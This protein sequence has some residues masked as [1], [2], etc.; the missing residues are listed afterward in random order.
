MFSPPLCDHLT[1]YHSFIQF[2][3]SI[4]I[5]FSCCSPNVLLRTRVRHAI[6]VCQQYANPAQP[7]FFIH[8]SQREKGWRISITFLLLLASARFTHINQRSILLNANKKNKY[9]N[10]LETQSLIF[11]KNVQFSFALSLTARFFLL[12]G[13]LIAWNFC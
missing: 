11:K 7:K 1:L 4:S 6:C 5:H 9:V 2:I 8:Y 12:T 10:R 3:H 13:S